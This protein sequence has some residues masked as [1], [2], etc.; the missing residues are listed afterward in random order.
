M[1]H[2][3]G[4]GLSF[5]TFIC[6]W[7]VFHHEEEQ[8]SAR[9]TLPRS[10]IVSA[11]VATSA[12]ATY[13]RVDGNPNLRRHLRYTAAPG[14]VLACG[15]EAD[16][17]MRGAAAGTGFC[18]DQLKV[19][20]CVSAGVT[21]VQDKAV[22]VGCDA[23][24]GKALDVCA[25]GLDPFQPSICDLAG[26]ALGSALR[27]ASGCPGGLRRVCTDSLASTLGVTAYY[28][29]ASCAISSATMATWLRATMCVT[30]KKAQAF[31]DCIIACR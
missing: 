7:K 26:D 5:A 9:W 23:Q 6:S 17:R 28:E 8:V 2:V 20:A 18:S 1:N 25:A 24:L 30:P 4:R 21:C 19:V 10:S 22:T 31:A 14:T 16:T 29:A 27:A 13:V 12:A 11:A 15:D 3:Q